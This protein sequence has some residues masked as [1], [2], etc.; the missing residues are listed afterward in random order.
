MI[1]MQCH[2]GEADLGDDPQSIGR[3][4]L[5]NRTAVRR[6][7]HGTG[8]AAQVVECLI[9]IDSGEV[10]AD[11]LMQQFTMQ[12]IA[13]KRLAIVDLADQTLQA[14]LQGGALISAHALR[15]PGKGVVFATLGV[16]LGSLPGSAAGFGLGGFQNQF[17]AEREVATF[18]DHLTSQAQLGFHINQIRGNFARKFACVHRTVVA[19]GFGHE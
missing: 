6:L 19:M 4:D 3:L 13:F 7:A 1:D 18:A 15:I 16:A 2:A 11:G 8:R 14:G 5:S 12:G 17:S 9:G 10:G